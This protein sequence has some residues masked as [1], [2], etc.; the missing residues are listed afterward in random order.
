MQYQTNSVVN[1]D[2]QSTEKTELDQSSEP[3]RPSFL[4]AT[5]DEQRKAL[6]SL[7]HEV[8][9]LM[10]LSAPLTNQKQIKLE[11]N[12]LEEHEDSSMIIHE[13]R[14]NTY[15]VK[16]IRNMVLYLKELLEV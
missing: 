8:A 16:E 13:L 11:P 12:I 3:V 15:R 4:L 6:E 10:A 1:H 7:Q 14:G 2:G 5:I 9:L